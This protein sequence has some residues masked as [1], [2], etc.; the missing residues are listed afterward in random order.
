VA[1]KNPAYR[2]AQWAVREVVRRV[3]DGGPRPALA[4]VQQQHA[5]V[6]GVMADNGLDGSSPVIGFAFG[7]LGFA[8]EQALWGGEVLI[9]DYDRYHR[10]ARLATIPLPGDEEI[11]LQRPYRAALGHMAAAGVP[12]DGRLLSVAATPA[13]ERQLLARE[14]ATVLKTQSSSMRLL[15]DAVASIT[16]VCHVA[17]YDGQ[18]A[19]QLESVARA[20]LGQD[21]VAYALPLMEGPAGDPRLWDARPLITNI[22]KDIAGGAP[23][24]IVAARFHRALA[25]AIAEAA[26]L[27]RR[28]TL[29]RTVALSGELFGNVVLQRL[30]TRALRADGFTVLWHRRVPPGDACLALGQLMIGARNR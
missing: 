19:A 2:S 10:F 30:T 1:D 21:H 14:L 23:A 8:D 17:Q 11:V 12:W 18:A 26:R 25:N 22:A 24:R 6:A 5:H 9:A 28:E 7:G 27:A 20:G 3:T 4:R 15:V 16:G 29:I 13:A